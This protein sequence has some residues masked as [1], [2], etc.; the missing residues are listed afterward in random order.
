MLGKH[1]LCCGIKSPHCYRRSGLA[2]TLWA[3]GA[4]DLRVRQILWAVSFRQ[5]SFPGID[6]KIAITY[7]HYLVPH[8][9]WVVNTSVQ[10]LFAPCVSRGWREGGSNRQN[11]AHVLLCPSIGIQ[12]LPGFEMGSPMLVF[13]FSSCTGPG[14]SPSSAGTS[15]LCVWTKKEKKN[16]YCLG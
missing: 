12:H 14:S 1:C 8:T 9:F 2:C 10:Y 7:P 11:N 4:G 16:L 13:K 15:W 5:M 6:F 3:D